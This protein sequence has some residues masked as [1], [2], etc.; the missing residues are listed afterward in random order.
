M[1]CSYVGIARLNGLPGCVL[2]LVGRLGVVRDL[3]VCRNR[4]L[5]RIELRVQCRAVLFEEPVGL[6][7]LL[8]VRP[9][10]LKGSLRLLEQLP[11]A[12]KLCFLLVV[13]GLSRLKLPALLR[14]LPLAAGKFVLACGKLT[15]SFGQLLFAV[16][17]LPFPVRQL[18][19]AISELLLPEAPI[20]LDDALVAFDD[21]RARVALQVLA[22]EAQ[23][24]QIL[25]FTCQSRERRLAAAK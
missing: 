16:R 2:L 11:I 20:V 24:R 13:G 14:K 19:L 18:L 10:Q 22:E 21:E 17:Q 12:R 3:L 9:H 6:H 7:G 25:L 8:V 4:L 5:E 23:S 15:L 1:C